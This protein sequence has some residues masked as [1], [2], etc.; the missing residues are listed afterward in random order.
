M[1]NNFIKL[2]IM[3]LRLCNAPAIFQKEVNRIFFDLIGN[4]FFIYIDYLEVFSNSW[5]QHVKVFKNI[6]RILKNN[7][8][9]SKTPS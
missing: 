6:F 5:E 2:Y 8:N 4:C 7:R 1:M 3:P 9:G